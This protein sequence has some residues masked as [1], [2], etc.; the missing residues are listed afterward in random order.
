[1]IHTLNEKEQ[2]IMLLVNGNIQPKN[3]FEW[4]YRI[5]L[6][7]EARKF[8][9]KKRKLAEKERE[10]FENVFQI[11]NIKYNVLSKNIINL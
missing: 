7:Y 2:Y 10:D 9:E 4:I 3:P 5:W 6:R 11:R 8:Y 1:M